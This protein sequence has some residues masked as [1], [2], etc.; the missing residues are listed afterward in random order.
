MFGMVYTQITERTKLH[1]KGEITW[2]KLQNF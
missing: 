2:H 1:M